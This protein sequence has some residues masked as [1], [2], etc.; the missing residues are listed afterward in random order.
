MDRE[1]V[2]EG[3]KL[4]S[5]ALKDLDRGVDDILAGLQDQPGRESHDSRQ[6][7]EIRL[8]LEFDRAEGEGLTREEASKACRRHGFEPQTVGAWATAKFLVTGP[9]GRRYLTDVGRQWIKEHNAGMV[10]DL[11]GPKAGFMLGRKDAKD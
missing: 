11:R 9:D 10:I 8:L 6:E 1:L 5:R 2:I 4:V 7:R 3:L